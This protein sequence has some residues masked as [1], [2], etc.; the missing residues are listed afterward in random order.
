MSDVPQPI[1]VKC[2]CSEDD[3]SGNPAGVYINLVLDD[4]TKQQIARNLNLPVTV[5]VSD[6]ESDIPQIEYFYPNKKM[7]LCL[8]GTLAAAYVFFTGRQQK[9]MMF[10]TPNGKILKLNKDVDGN[11]EVGVC[12]ESVNQPSI[13]SLTVGADLLN[14][15]IGDISKT[16]PF[17]VASVGSPKLLIPVSSADILANL[18]PNHLEIEKWSIANK[19]NGI[20]VYSGYDERADS[21]VARGFNPLTGHNEDAATGVAAA[22]L[23]YQLKKSITVKQGHMLGLACKINVRYANQNSLWVSGKVKTLK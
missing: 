19:V 20:Y 2:F 16:L 4:E 1:I 13:L 22:A 14:I 11:F 7:P 15:D 3:K 5:F 6:N 23:S 18:S 12:A 9:N 10:S 8:H 21:F 17:V